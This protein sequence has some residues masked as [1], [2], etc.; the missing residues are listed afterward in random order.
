MLISKTTV[1]WVNECAGGKV[2][3]L[4]SVFSAND[5]FMLC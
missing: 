3:Y 2:L 1:D 5:S 4:L